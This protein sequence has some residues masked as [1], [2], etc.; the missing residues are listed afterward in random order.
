M[1][2]A[3]CTRAA[4]SKTVVWFQKLRSDNGAVVH[5]GDDRAGGGNGDNEIIKV[6]LDQLPQGV[7]T[8]IFTVNS[9]LNDSFKGIPNARC[10]LLNGKNDQE[11]A[12]FDLTLDGGDHTGMVMAK[13]YLQSNTWHMQAIGDKGRGRT[14]QEMGDIIT[15]NLSNPVRRTPL[16]D[17]QSGQSA[18]LDGYAS[19]QNAPVSTGAL[20]LTVTAQPQAN[21]PSLDLNLFLLDAAGR[22]IG[23]EGFIFYGN[24]S[25]PKDGIELNAAELSARC[26]PARIRGSVQRVIIALSIDTAVAGHPDLFG[27]LRGPPPGRRRRD[28]SGVCD[29]DSRA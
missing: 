28:R 26:E 2:L 16:L 6:N 5:T 10:R 19:G 13:L 22:V 7:D 24:N 17:M 1:R 20:T 23:D 9:F 14:F 3:C 27:I 18:R 21:A 25:A 29:P 12:R 11:L 4:S 8:L 15:A